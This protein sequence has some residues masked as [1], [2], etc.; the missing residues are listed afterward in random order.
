MSHHTLIASRAPCRILGIVFLALFYGLLFLVLDTDFKG[1]QSRFGAILAGMGFL[2]LILFTV[3]I[4][5]YMKIRPVFYRE[6]AS[7]MY[8][9]TVYPITLI[10]AEFPW[11][12]AIS[13]I[14]TCIFYFMAHFKVGMSRVG[15]GRGGRGGA[16]WLVEDVECCPMCACSAH[17][18]WHRLLPVVNRR[19][20]PLQLQLPRWSGGAPSVPLHSEEFGLGWGH[21]IIELHYSPLTSQVDAGKFFFFYLG[22]T[23]CAMAFFYAGLT[24]SSM[25]PTSL[26]AQVGGGGELLAA[27]DSSIPVP[28]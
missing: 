13:A 6:V 9:K 26:L 17:A 16:R 1:T 20:A 3:S 18:C 10:M 12:V 25:M 8:A 7:R 23:V 2:G 22:T 14:F 15:R 4:P 21:T 19:H 11:L 27:S 5:L 28:V 24:A